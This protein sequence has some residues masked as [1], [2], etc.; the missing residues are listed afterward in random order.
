MLYFFF[1]AWPAAPRP[2]PVYM[3]YIGIVNLWPLEKRMAKKM[4]N[5]METRMPEPTV[6]V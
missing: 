5:D 1:Q 6:P 3:G 4:E 2:N